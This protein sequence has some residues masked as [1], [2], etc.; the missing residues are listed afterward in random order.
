MFSHHL[1]KDMKWETFFWIDW[2]LETIFN[3]PDKVW[4]KGLL[5]EMS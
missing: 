5:F 4:H 2:V 1:M 3:V